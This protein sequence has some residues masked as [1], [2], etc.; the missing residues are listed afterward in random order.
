MGVALERVIKMY[1]D[2]EGEIVR[3]RDVTHVLRASS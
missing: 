3:G 2:A 1:M